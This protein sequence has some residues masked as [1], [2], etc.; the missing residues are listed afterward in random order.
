MK[1]VG[2]ETGLGWDPVKKIVDATDE[3]WAK[4]LQ[5]I[6]EAAKFRNADMENNGHDT[7]HCISDADNGEEEKE[8][9]IDFV[10][11][12]KLMVASKYYTTYMVKEPCRTSLHIGHKFV[13]E[14]LNG[15]HDRCHQ[16]FR[17]EKYI[18]HALCKELNERYNLTGT[19]NITIEEMVGIFLITLG[20][21]FGNR[22][23]QER[24][25]H[26]GETISRHFNNV[27]MSISRMTVDIINPTDREFKDIPKKIREDERYWPYF[28]DCIGA[29]DKTHVPVIISPTKQIP[30]IGRKGITTQNVMA[31]CDFDMRFTFVWA[32]WEGIAHD[33]HFYGSYSKRRIE[34][35]TST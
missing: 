20:H 23:A 32:G 29:I 21:G 9:D 18:F 3:W 26:S 5:E 15:H 30:F 22:M 34:L 13:M 2:K 33:T 4:K 12:L 7:E 16:Q 24:F 35:S 14:I 11:A 8:D 10:I 17:M 27:L 6:S 28:K 25:Q 1:L 19:Q 31:V